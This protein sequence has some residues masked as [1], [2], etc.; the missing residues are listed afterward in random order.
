VHVVR[1]QL[2][3][4]IVTD[5]GKYGT[6]GEIYRTTMTTAL[7]VRLMAELTQLAHSLAPACA[8]LP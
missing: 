3:Q 4:Q 5:L 1:G 6:D 7:R 2:N 8:N